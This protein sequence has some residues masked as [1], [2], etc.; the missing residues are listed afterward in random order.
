MKRIFAATELTVMVF[1]FIFCNIGSVPALS[2]LSCCAIA[3]AS[4]KETLTDIQSETDDEEI[5]EDTP[6]MY[7]FTFENLAELKKAYTFL[8]EKIFVNLVENCENYGRGDILSKEH[9]KKIIEMAEST[10]V[11]LFDGK[12]ENSYEMDYYHG[13]KWMAQWISVSDG[14]H[15]MCR[16][17]QTENSTTTSNDN[18]DGFVKELTKDGITAKVYYRD[19]FSVEMQIDG[20]SMWY[21]APGAQSVEEIEADFARFEFIKIKDLINDPKDPV[22]W[23]VRAIEFVKSLF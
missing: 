7:F 15:I 3:Y 8:P 19:E 4:E 10:T 14:R 23:L 16:Y 9:A 5:L 1:L 2:N 22:M 12:T 21:R 13:A 6:F 11:I 18:S 17:Y 20:T